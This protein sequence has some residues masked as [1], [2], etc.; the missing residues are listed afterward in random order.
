VA[1]PHPEDPKKE[2]FHW[3]EMCDAVQDEA[4]KIDGVAVSNFVLPLYFTQFAE[5]GG[6]NDFLG[7]LTK[8][9]ALQSFA[10]NPGG[11]IGFYNPKTRDHETFSLKGDHRARARQ[12]IKSRG[13][14]ARRSVRYKLGTEFK[15]ELEAMTAGVARR[16]A[17]PT[18][19]PP[20]RRAV[21][22]IDQSPQRPGPGVN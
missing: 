20:E 7:R 6:R 16:R 8:G 18:R 15:K 9:K 22:M 2:V 19:R 10:I 1:G 17:R 5:V 12:K 11:Y 3:Y 13:Q 21:E 14:L 4:Y